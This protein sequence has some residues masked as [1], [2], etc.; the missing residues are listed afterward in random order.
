MI[1]PGSHALVVDPLPA[2][3]EQSAPIDAADQS[4][5]TGLPPALLDRFKREAGRVRLVGGSLLVWNVRTVHQCWN[6]GPRL[7]FPVSFA[8][9]SRRTAD[10]LGDKREWVVKGNATTSCPLAGLLHPY[11]ALEPNTDEQFPLRAFAHL[12]A[13]DESGEPLP[14]IEALL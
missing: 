10:A 1:W 7:A 5:W 8:P 3:E 12:W 4:L 6:V 2:E 11:S 13:L 9:K 14:Q